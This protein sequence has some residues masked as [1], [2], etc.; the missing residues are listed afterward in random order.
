MKAFKFL[1]VALPAMAVAACTVNRADAPPALTGP[2]GPA[3]TI[4]IRATP[5]TITQDGQS[6]STIAVTMLR[7]GQGVA[8]QE[9]RFDMTVNGI[10]ADFGTFRPGRTARTDASGLATVTFTAPPAAPVGRVQ[11]CDGLPG[12]CV[13]IVATPTG[14][15]FQFAQH[16]QV[17]IRLAPPSV[18]VP[19]ADPAAPIASFVIATNPVRVGDQAIFNASSSRATAGRTIT[20]YAWDFGDGTRKSGVTTQHDFDD[21]GVFIVTLTVTDNF[22]LQGVF[23]S[24]ITIVS[25]SSGSSA[26]RP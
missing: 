11:T 7:L 6:V 23:S 3:E 1:A 26:P 14:S 2:S 4:D 16:P 25:T 20:S 22:G 8:N 21:V 10:A 5:D 24:P 9:F 18:I 17:R 12:I 19:P 13:D 15:S